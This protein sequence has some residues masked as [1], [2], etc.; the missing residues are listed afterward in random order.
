M[1]NGLNKQTE[2]I[3][4]EFLTE[5]V[6]EAASWVKEKLAQLEAKAKDE[7]SIGDMFKM[8][9]VMNKLS[10]TSDMASSVASATHQA[11]TSLTRGIK[12]Q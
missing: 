5:H 11:I 8:Q 12:G 6:E 3:S 9:L 10:Q 4:I 1:S 2:G 7:I